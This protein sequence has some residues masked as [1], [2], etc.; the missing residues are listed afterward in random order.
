MA[1]QV[2]YE[3]IPKPI[4]GTRGKKSRV[5]RIQRLFFSLW[6]SLLRQRGDLEGE[7]CQGRKGAV[8]D[9]KWEQLRLWALPGAGAKTGM[10]LWGWRVGRGAVQQKWNVGTRHTSPGPPQCSLPQE[11]PSC[12]SRC[13]AP[14]G[15]R[16]APQGSRLGVCV[17]ECVS[18]IFLFLLSSARFHSRFPLN[19]YVCLRKRRKHRNL[20]MYPKQWNCIW[21][22]CGQ[23]QMSACVCVCVC[24]CVCVKYCVDKRPESLAELLFV[25]MFETEG[26]SKGSFRVISCCVH[27]VGTSRPTRWSLINYK[28]KSATF[29]QK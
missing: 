24:M 16:E 13:K 8:A 23:N 29:W 21:V 6:E 9:M 22:Q 20:K 17:H 2:I 7:N 14:P 3:N 15:T 27:S 28:Y 26:P 4:I 10:C 1:S 11:A 25:R 18:K 5:T 12:H 19:L